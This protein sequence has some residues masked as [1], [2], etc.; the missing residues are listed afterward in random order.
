MASGG[1]PWLNA[2][3]S[4]GRPETGSWVRGVAETSDAMD[5]EPGLFNRSARGIAAGLKRA[6]LESPRTKGTKFQSAMSMLNFFINRAGRGLPPGRKAEL[7]RAKAELRELF[8][9]PYQGRKNMA[10]KHSRKGG[11][12]KETAFRDARPLEGR[13][14]GLRAREHSAVAGPGKTAR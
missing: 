9:K 6:A 3:M 4:R 7:E 8:G 13:K 5:I 14:H 2:G 10:R 11:R 12:H 1:K